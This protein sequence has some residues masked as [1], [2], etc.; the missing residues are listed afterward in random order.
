MSKQYTVTKFGTEMAITVE[1]GSA[2]EAAIKA[3]K[4]MGINQFE[5]TTAAKLTKDGW[6]YYGNVY[7]VGAKGDT[8]CRA[9]YIVAEVV[10]VVEPTTITIA[11]YVW[12]FTP[13]ADGKTL[14]NSERV[15]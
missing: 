15:R 9:K 4:I 7:S 8:I 10:E 12:T 14:W 5:T 13:I 11:E 6:S 2:R 1:A 3:D